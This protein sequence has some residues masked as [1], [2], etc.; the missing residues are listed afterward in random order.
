MLRILLQ[1][2]VRERRET[3]EISMLK[4]IRGDI[5]ICIYYILYYICISY[6]IYIWYHM[7]TQNMI[8][9]ICFF[10]KEKRYE[11]YSVYI[12]NFINDNMEH[13]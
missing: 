4:G 7:H 11:I 8:F 3:Y 9:N 6:D 10:T 5:Y 1:K 13:G 12:L 2:Y